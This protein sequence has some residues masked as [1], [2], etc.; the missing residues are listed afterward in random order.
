LVPHQPHLI[1]R[2]TFK[3]SA[4]ASQLAGAREKETAFA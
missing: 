3:H 4:H 2:A 1:M